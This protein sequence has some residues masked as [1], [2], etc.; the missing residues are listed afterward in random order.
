VMRLPGIFPSPT[1]PPS[2]CHFHPRCPKVMQR[3]R[4]AYPETS[5]FGD[6]HRARCFLY[7]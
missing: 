3:C 6:T 4:E 2:G 1:N 7:D 5:A